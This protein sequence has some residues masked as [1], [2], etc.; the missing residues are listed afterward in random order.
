MISE[1]RRE[2]VNKVNEE[3][4]A[5]AVMIGILFWGE[6]RHWCKTSIIAT[7]A[8]TCI[9]TYSDFHLNSSSLIVKSHVSVDVDVAL[10]MDS[11]APTT[12]NHPSVNSVALFLPHKRSIFLGEGNLPLLQ[13]SLSSSTFGVL[14]QHEPFHPPRLA[15]HTWVCLVLRS[16]V[17][18]TRE[19]A[20]WWQE[21]CT[22]TTQW[23]SSCSG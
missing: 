9:N 1:Q 23:N 14:E 17:Y 11:L 21:R 6:C 4:V 10:W 2:F 16:Y 15:T 12:T 18:D 3:F 13:H 19:K 5:L 20:R 8:C 7:C 22:S